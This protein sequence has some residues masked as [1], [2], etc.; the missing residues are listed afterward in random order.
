M[1]VSNVCASFVFVSLDVSGYSP[2]ILIGE[3]CDGEITADLRN[4]TDN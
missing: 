4:C 1:F 3:L 2:V